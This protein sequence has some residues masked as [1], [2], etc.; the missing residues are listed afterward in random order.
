[1][2]NIFRKLLF[3]FVLF[4]FIFS[5]YKVISYYYSSFE[6]ENNFNKLEEQII[7]E[8]DSTRVMSFTEKYEKLLNQNQDMVAWIKIEDTKVNYPVMHTPKDEEYYLRRNFDKEYE[9]RGTPFLNKEANL[10][11]RDDNIIIYAHNMDDNTMF[12]DLK[13]Y[14]NY[15]FYKNHKIISFENKYEN[16]KYEIFAVFKTVD[17][18]DH[19]LY[20]DYYNFINAN[21]ENHFN[22]QINLYKNASFYETDIH[23]QYGDKLLTLSTCEY[24]N[25]HGRLVV[26]A[27]KI[28][29]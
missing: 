2:K 26:V 28:V 22:K 29:E 11:D 7:T 23:P 6:S 10:K 4:I 15:D 8:P 16:D 3:I 17:I 14:K 9:F 19:E 24:S 12:G 5:A 25:D 21:D 27:R 13:K 20:I 1:M 18:L